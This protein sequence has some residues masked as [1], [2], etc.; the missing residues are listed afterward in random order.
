MKKRRFSNRKATKGRKRQIV[1][2]APVKTKIDG[3]FTANK[4][5]KYADNPKAKPIKVICHV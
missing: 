5:V 4:H 1:M 2:S 3:V